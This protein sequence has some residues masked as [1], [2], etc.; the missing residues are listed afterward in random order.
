MGKKVLITGAGGYIGSITTKTFLEQGY[1]VIGIDNFS[2]G[3][4]K[5]LQ[6]LRQQHPDKLRYYNVNL[7]DNF[8]YIFLKEKDIDAIIHFAALAVVDESMKF[9]QKY[10]ENNVCGSINLLSSAANHGIKN[11]IFS[12]TCAVYGKPDKMPIDEE[13]NLN[14]SNPYGE[15]KLLTERIIRWYHEL[16]NLNFIIF[17]YFNVCGAS[18]DGTIGYSKTPSTLLVQ[19]A[20]KGALGIEPFYLTYP[21][22]GT[23][24]GSPI[25]DYVNVVDLAEAHLKAVEYLVGGGKSEII[26]LGTGS[27]SSVLE[28]VN[29]VQQVT[30]VK[31]EPSQSTPRQ[32]EYEITIASIEKAKKIL[33]WTP[34][35][36][37]SD[38]INTLVSWFKA[39]PKGWNDGEEIK[40]PQL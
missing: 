30:G 6:F 31:F 35:R 7:K 22:V 32:G 29:K 26:N 33:E 28:I 20:V 13:N 39:H 16:L 5:P 19:N 40:V 24:D 37:L 3:F 2:T 34:K 38:S 18:D 27:G 25:R 4:E 23:P 21:K 1:E 10:F 11:I 9:P 12:S 14:P 17:R 15:S 8:S 36:T